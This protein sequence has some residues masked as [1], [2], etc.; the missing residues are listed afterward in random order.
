MA[1]ARLELDA[2]TK[3]D[4]GEVSRQFN[5]QEGTLPILGSKNDLL[6]DYLA[7]QASSISN[8]RSAPSTLETDVWS[9]V[10]PA[11]IEPIKLPKEKNL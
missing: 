2:V 4:D 10:N 1:V 6:Q 11:T 9:L 5:E 8:V 7:T 3:I